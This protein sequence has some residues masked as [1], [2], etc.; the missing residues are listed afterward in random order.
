MQSLYVRHLWI[1]NVNVIKLKKVT[2]K[3]G[4]KLP[5]VAKKSW[6]GGFDR[7]APATH[8]RWRRFR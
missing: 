5:M 7:D 4:K 8:D 2:C 3:M 6:P 1:T